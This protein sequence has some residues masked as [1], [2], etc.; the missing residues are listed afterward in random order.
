MDEIISSASLILAT[1]ALLYTVWN[2][3]IEKSININTDRLYKDAEK[4]HQKLKATLNYQSLPLALFST[5]MA[6]I[7]FPL[8]SDLFIDS[9]SIFYRCKIKN[10]ITC[11]Y[12][13][14]TAVLIFIEI[15]FIFLSYYLW[16]IYNKINKKNKI[17]DRKKQSISEHS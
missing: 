5:I 17:L 11:K 4:D 6:I 8:V 13:T 2:P 1:I 7:Y 14:I 15:C 16:S 12:D 9:S 3:T 10:L